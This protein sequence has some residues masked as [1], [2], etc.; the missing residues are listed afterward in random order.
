MIVRIPWLVTPAEPPKAPNEEADPNAI[1]GTGGGGAQVATV[2]F[3]T[4]LLAM[5]FAGIAKSFTPLAPPLI[6]A[7]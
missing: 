3:H 5:L 7:V 6:V 1:D 2:K 4:K